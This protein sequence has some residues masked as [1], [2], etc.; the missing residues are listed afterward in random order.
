MFDLGL[1][2]EQEQLC[3]AYRSVFEREGG[4]EVVR[5]TEDEGFSPALWARVAELGGVDMALPEQLGGGGALFLDV[6]LVCELVGHHLAPVPLAES[7]A[8]A[9]LLGA[10]GGDEARSLL[11]DTLAAGAPLTLTPR[12]ASGD[13]LPWVPAGAVADLVVARDG[14]RIIAVR[15]GERQVFP[16]NLGSLALAHRG[17][18]DPVV[19][20]EGPAAIQ[21]FTDALLEWRALVA[22]QLVGAAHRV[23]E[24]GVD[25]TTERYAFGVPIASFQSIAHKMADA[26]AAVDGAELLA[27]KAAWAVDAQP[28]HWRSLPLM[29]FVMAGTAAEH[30]ADQV[31]HFHGGYGFTLEYDIQLYFR[32]IK[33]WSLQDGDRRKALAQVADL[34]WGP[35]SAAQPPAGRQGPGLVAAR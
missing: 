5:A 13:R 31:L 3:A 2:D 34:R 25:Y 1:S 15:G 4:P 10:L 32:R 19:V 33:A 35:P 26:A 20:G 6:A 18:V 7:A 8:A 21:T 17:V 24:I 27:R 14:D 29:A 22:S 12:Q 11:A 9:R 16:R 23:V 28:E 30:A